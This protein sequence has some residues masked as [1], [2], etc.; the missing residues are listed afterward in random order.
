[1]ISCF[2][3]HCDKAFNWNS[4]WKVDSFWL[5]VWVHYSGESIWWGRYVVEKVNISQIICKNVNMKLFTHILMDPAIHI[6]QL[7]CTSQWFHTL[8]IQHHE[9][10]NTCSNTW[11]WGTLHIQ[12]KHVEYPAHPNQ[13]CRISNVTKD[14]VKWGQ[15]YPDLRRCLEVEWEWWEDVGSSLACLRE[16]PLSFCTIFL[17]QEKEIVMVG[18]IKL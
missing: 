14:S 7:V 10:R 18:E 8:P 12:T 3:L 9:L 16:I 5:G 15:K 4:L 11:A 17:S 6:L 1:M 13:T 2:S